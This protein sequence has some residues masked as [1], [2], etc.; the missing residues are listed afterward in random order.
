MSGPNAF[1][2]TIMEF[3]QAHCHNALTDRLFPLVTYLGESGVFWIAL[4]LLFLLFGKKSG[5][6]STGLL[7]LCSMLAG[8]ILGEACLKNI[9]CRPRPFMDFPDY[10]SLLIPP[11]SGFSFPSG[12]S[13]A[14]FAAAGSVFRRDRR[15]GA[16]ALALA[17]L[18]AFSR[19]FLF[20]H[21]PTDVLA[22]A[23]LGALCAAGVS[24]I[25]PRIEEKWRRRR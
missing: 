5:W 6:R 3:I 17:G 7:M 13:C 12:H 20:V 2:Q 22:G 9:I 10:T 1:D 15:W 21:Y 4:A 25:Y 18:I 24:W 14:S 23:A 19:V 11:P 8:L 16:A